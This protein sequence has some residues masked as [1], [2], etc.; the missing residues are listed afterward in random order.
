MAQTLDD[1]VRARLGVRTTTR[2]NDQLSSVGTTAARALIQ[3]PNRVAFYIGNLSVNV[4]FTGPFNNVSSTRGIR[5]N[6]SGG[7]LTALWDED[8]QVVGWEWFVIADA[9][10]STLLTI[11]WLTLKEPEA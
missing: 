2:I 10:A 6:P 8:F 5:L 9:A 4:L 3:D 11:E 1:L 7:F